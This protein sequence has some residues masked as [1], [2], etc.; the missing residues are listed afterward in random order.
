[1][2]LNS[3]SMTSLVMSAPFGP[4]GPGGPAGPGGPYWKWK[5][6]EYMHALP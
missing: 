5:I 6:E 4:G 1:M 3:S 2:S